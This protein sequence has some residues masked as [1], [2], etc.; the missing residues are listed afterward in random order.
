LY[1]KYREWQDL[2]SILSSLSRLKAENG[3]LTTIAQV[4]SGLFLL[5]GLCF[6]GWNLGLPEEIW[7]LLKGI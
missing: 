4:C 7:K 1:V 6:T 5:V 2:A 3:N